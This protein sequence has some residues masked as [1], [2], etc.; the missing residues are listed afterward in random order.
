MIVVGLTGG[1]GSGKSTVGTMFQNLGVPV[2]NS[3][4]RAKCLMNTS[5]KIRK[6]LIS[7]FGEKAYLEEELNRAY[8][9]KKVFKDADLLAELNR[10][11]H[12]QVRK[13]FLKWAKKQKTPY[14][15]QETALL[16]ENKAKELYDRVILVTAS[17]ELRI[18][19]VLRRSESTREQI[20]ARMNNQLDDATKIKL[21]DYIIENIDLER[22]S[23]KVLNIHGRILTDC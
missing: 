21:A 13:D 8:I 22:T 11:V 7:L 16:F 6:E 5:K 10:I 17:K 19:R 14:V 23:L 18:E 2:Y 4:E 15:I 3:D 1:I 9:A 20:V 12:P